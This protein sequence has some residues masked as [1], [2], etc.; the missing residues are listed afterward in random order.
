MTYS[1]IIDKKWQKR[2]QESNLAAFNKENIDNKLYVLEMFSYPSGANLHVGHWYNYSQADIYARLKKMQG[3]EVFQ[4]MG[5]DSFG[6][7]AENFAIKTGIHPKDSTEKNIETMTKQLKALGG[8][9][10]W[11]HTLST[12]DPEYYRWNQWIFLQLY[13]KG[14]AYRK[15][16][17]VNWCPSCNTVLANE[18]VMANGCCERCDQPVEKKKLTQW[19]FKITEYADE[20]LDCLKDMDWPEPTKKIQ[21]HWIGRSEGSEIKFRAIKD[22]SPL[23]QEDGSELYLKVFTTRADTLQGVTYVVVA[24]D[25]ELCDVLTTEEQ[26]AVVEAYQ[27]QAKLKSDIDRMSTVNEKTGVFSGSYAEHPISG[28]KVPVWVADY[29]IASYGEGVVMAVPAHDER[30]FAFAQKYDLPVKRVIKATDSSEAE[31]PFVDDGLLYNSSTY[32]GLS[33][34]EARKKITADLSERGLAQS[35][36]NYRLRDW[37]VSRQRYWG[38]PIPIIYC[39]KCGAVPVPE[40]DLP[41]ELPYNVEFRPDGD[42]PLKSSEEFMHC[43]CPQCGGPALR[44]PDTLDTFVDSSWYMFRYVDN[45]N[46]Q[47]LFSQDKVNALCPVDVYIG[48]KEHAAMHLLYARFFTKA[49]R[50]MGYLNFDEPFTRLIHQGIILG[51]DS[52]KMSKS[53]GNT[54]SPDTYVNEGGSDLLRLYLSFGF[55]FTEGGPWNDGGIKA[56]SRFISRIEKLVEDNLEIAKNYSFMEAEP[57]PQNKEDKDLLHVLHYSIEQITQDA[58]RFQFNTCVARCMELVNALYDYQ[59][60]EEKNPQLELYTLQ[61]LLTLLAPFAPHFTEEMAEQLGNESSLFTHPWPQAKQEYVQLDKVEIAVQVNGKIV[62]RMNVP[63]EASREDIQKAV[64][65]HANYTSWL[66]GKTAVKTIVVPNRLVNI[67]V[68]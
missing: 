42:S 67:V 23:K 19:F 55:A 34:A 15:K 38:T 13:K 60:V 47:E 40:E 50:D 56:V 65:A 21:E 3:Y 49:L 46:E 14:L 54:V 51:P 53:K 6:L 11:D 31:L 43:T 57:K 25:S 68:K 22:G 58:E 5:F 26:K 24:P 36:I 62:D 33:S 48:G 41:V 10:N 9:F 45:K 59:K 8:M 61:A 18:Q 2:W 20:L 64:E 66:D 39:E 27:E 32:D 63:S 29:V 28:E 44:D 37:L 52:Q 12:C 30:D 17:P 35:K 4:P 16:A 1:P 7:P